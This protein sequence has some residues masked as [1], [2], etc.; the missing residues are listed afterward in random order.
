MLGA[1]AACGGANHS[2]A[3]AGWFTRAY[4]SG[5]PYS[6]LRDFIDRLETTDRL[7][8]VNAPVSPYLEATE[9]QTRLLA[10]GGPAALF[11]NVTREAGGA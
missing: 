9:I 10:E 2:P 4:I 1:A 3:L 8:R 11:E 6:S 5:M 7:V